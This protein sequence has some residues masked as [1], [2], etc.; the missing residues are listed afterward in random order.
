MT[1]STFAKGSGWPRRSDLQQNTPA[2]LAI[3]DAL[4]A[5]EAVGADPVVEKRRLKEAI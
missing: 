1:E 2:E 4:I 3:R 5:V